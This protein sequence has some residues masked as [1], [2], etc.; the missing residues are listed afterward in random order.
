M[1]AYVTAMLLDLECVRKVN[2]YNKVR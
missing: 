1:L 2:A